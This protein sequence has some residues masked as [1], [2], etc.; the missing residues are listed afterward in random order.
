MGIFS[1]AI[2]LFSHVNNAV[3]REKI[4]VLDFELNDITSLPEK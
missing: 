3:A 2:A 1:I 4:A